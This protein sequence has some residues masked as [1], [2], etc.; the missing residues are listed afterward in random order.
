MWF[1]L[2]KGRK[3]E[4]RMNKCNYFQN[5]NNSISHYW[6]ATQSLASQLST[7]TLPPQPHQNIGIIHF[8]AENE[9]NFI[10]CLC[11]IPVSFTHKQA[12]HLWV[13]IR[14]T[15]RHQTND[16]IITNA[17]LLCLFFVL[18]CSVLLCLALLSLWSRVKLDAII[19]INLYE[20]ILH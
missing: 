1:S 6:S 9:I 8:I 18:V 11:L 14:Q 19:C 3:I 7:T 16:T 15:N 13:E 17:T 5:S 2:R 12:V 20:S 10:I 4:Q